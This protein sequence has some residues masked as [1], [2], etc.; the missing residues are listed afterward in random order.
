[1]V[2]KVHKFAVTFDPDFY[3]TQNVLVKELIS[4]VGSAAQE[5]ESCLCLNF[6]DLGLELGIIEETSQ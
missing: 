5:D 2:S 1:M 3:M 6:R 4:L